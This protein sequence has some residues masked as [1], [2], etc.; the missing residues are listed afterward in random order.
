MERAVGRGLVAIACLS[1]AACGSAGG[2]ASAVDE[3]SADFSKADFAEARVLP[4]AGSW[5]DVELTLGGLDQFDRL[6]DTVHDGDRC[7][8]MVAIAA[9]IVG[10]RASFGTLL[11]HVE[12]K[13][14]FDATDRAT[15][16]T[17]RTDFDANALRTRDLHRLADCVMRAYA[18][19]S[20]N[21]GSTDGEAVAMIRAG[22]WASTRIG[23]KRPLDLLAA[24]RPGEIFP[25]SL[26]LTLD[27]KNWHWLLL[28][29]DSAG[30]PRL[31]NSDSVPVHVVRPGAA[32]DSML[33]NPTASF[34]LEESFH[35]E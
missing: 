25:M 10:G 30:S 27:G 13:R 4:Y 7:G 18:P 1:L 35:L 31:Y 24:L 12:G 6:K 23:S 20:W 33:A 26:D 14:A 22:G 2:D 32:F 16:A 17:I 21:V 11:T 3:S 5:L 34:N 28:W 15:L 19:H 8:A 29:K 9:A